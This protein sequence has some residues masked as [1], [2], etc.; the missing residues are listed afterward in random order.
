MSSRGTGRFGAIFSMLV[1][2]CVKD[3]NPLLGSHGAPEAI[4]I[5]ATAGVYPW[6]RDMLW[7]ILAGTGTYMVLV[8]L[9]W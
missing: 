4:G 6:R 1:V 9:V 3:V 2:Y 8:N 5:L 7:A